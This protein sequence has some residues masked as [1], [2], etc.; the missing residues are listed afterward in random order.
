[1]PLWWDVTEPDEV[2]RSLLWLVDGLAYAV[3]EALRRRPELRL[4][5]HR[6]RLPV[7]YQDGSRNRPVL[8]GPHGTTVSPTVVSRMTVMRATFGEA[9]RLAEVFADLLDDAER[10]VRQPGAWR[11]ALDTQIVA[12]DAWVDGFTHT[13]TFSR[14]LDDGAEQVLARAGAVERVVPAG[15]RAY[16]VVVGG[17]LDRA[18]LEAHLAAAAREVVPEPT[19]ADEIE[20]H[21]EVEPSDRDGFEWRLLLSDELVEALDAVDVAALLAGAGEVVRTA[22]DLAYVRTPLGRD[23]LTAAVHAALISALPASR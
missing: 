5:W 20:W 21:A 7:R 12:E 14:V 4:E 22:D 9:S 17:G 1:V 16:H 8:L 13:V 3:G 11:R 18:A 2:P 15:G 6:R 23:A 10:D 19:I